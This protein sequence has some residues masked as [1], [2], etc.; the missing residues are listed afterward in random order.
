MHTAIG[1][2]ETESIARGFLVS[3]AMVKKAP[4]DILLSKTIS[5]GKYIVLISGDVAS[6]QESVD[7]GR[8]VAESYLV[9]F[10][11]IPQLHEDVIAAIKGKFKKYSSNALGIVETKSVASAIIALDQSLK[12]AETTV[13]ELKLGQGLG[14]KGYFI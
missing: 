8:L 13:I 2:I 4:V 6:V 5:P 7:V 10:L 1:L 3:D 9:D 14:G 12:T 11:F